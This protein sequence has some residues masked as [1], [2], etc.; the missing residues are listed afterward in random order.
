M[1]KY[2]IPRPILNEKTNSFGRS[3]R[4]PLRKKYERASL[5]ANIPINQLNKRHRCTVIAPE[6]TFYN[7]A[8]K[9]NKPIIMVGGDCL[10]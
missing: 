2:P 7:R 4:Q 9:R 10:F 6:T 3:Q 5:F 1:G 8:T